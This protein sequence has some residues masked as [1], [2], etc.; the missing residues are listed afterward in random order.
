MTTVTIHQ[1]KTHLSKL[2]NRALTGEVIVVAKGRD[3]VIELKPVAP[4]AAK[5]RLGGIPGLVKKW[6]ADF[7]APL[8]GFSEYS[9]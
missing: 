4:K 1:A 2:V 7:D 8:D 3:P 9:P 6:P 5:R